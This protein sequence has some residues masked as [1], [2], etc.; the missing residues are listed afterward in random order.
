[1][2]ARAVWS[3]RE[4]GTETL[5]AWYWLNWENQAGGKG[6]SPPN[7]AHVFYP[8][9]SF[10]CP[11]QPGGILIE[12]SYVFVV[13]CWRNLFWLEKRWISQWLRRRSVS[14]GYTACK[15]KKRQYSRI[16]MLI[17]DGINSISLPRTLRSSACITSRMKFGNCKKQENNECKTQT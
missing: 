12:M 8:W 2:R 1:M 4:H 17:W 11:E 10:A 9:G 5:I 3:E 15:K 14:A 6:V 16:L 13:A 7:G